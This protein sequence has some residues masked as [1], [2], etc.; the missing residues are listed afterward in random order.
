MT[1]REMYRVALLPRRQG[2]F[3][4]RSR[5]IH[6]HGSASVVS[7]V[8]LLEHACNYNAITARCN[9]KERAETS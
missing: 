9:D 8:G 6:S 3:S 4:K 1:V 7:S 5:A 2:R